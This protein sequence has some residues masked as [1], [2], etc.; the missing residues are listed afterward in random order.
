MGEG[1]SFQSRAKHLL[2]QLQKRPVFKDCCVRLLLPDG[3]VLQLT[4]APSST[5]SYVQT[6]AAQVR[7]YGLGFRV[8]L[9]RKVVLLLLFLCCLLLLL[10]PLL[11][12]LLLLLFLLIRCACIYVCVCVLLPLL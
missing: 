4:F 9:L 8:L 10:L 7:V 11:L 6:T 2:Q 12:L 1:P 5:L 3:L